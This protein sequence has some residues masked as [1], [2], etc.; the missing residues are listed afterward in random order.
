MRKN[1]F[2]KTFNGSQERLISIVSEQNNFN[3]K[4]IKFNE[5][6]IHYVNLSFAATLFLYAIPGL[7]FFSIPLIFR[8]LITKIFIFMAVKF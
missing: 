8:H 3:K 2:S 1:D 5:H 7:N 6:L 4:L